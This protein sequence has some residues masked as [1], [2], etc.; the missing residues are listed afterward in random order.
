MKVTFVGTLPPIKAISHYCYFLAGSLSKIV[1]MEF[2]GF[3]E[4]IP[5]FLYSGGTKEQNES[6]THLKNVET[7]ILISWYN[8]LSWINTGLQC[9]GE[10]VHLQHWAYYS[11][12]FYC[13][14]LPILKIRGKKIVLTI[15]NITPH[16]KD[17]ISIFLDR[18]LNKILFS[19]ADTFIVHNQRNKQ[20]FMKLYNV[21][22]NRIFIVTHGTLKPYGRIIGVS[23][24]TARE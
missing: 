3:K 6:N 16:T 13:V 7:K 19:F 24:S 22:E 5:E 17:R 12:V 15:H 14:I 18:I 8:P 11:S 23:K 4:I 2:I 21:K 10:I 1:D 20:K 9:K